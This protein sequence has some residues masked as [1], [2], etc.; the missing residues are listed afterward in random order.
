[1]KKHSVCA[2]GTVGNV[3][4]LANGMWQQCPYWCCCCR[5]PV[6]DSVK[7][8]HLSS[9][10]TTLTGQIITCILHI[11]R[12]SMSLPLLLNNKLPSKPHLP[13]VQVHKAQTIPFTAV[14]DCIADC[15]T[16]TSF[17][18]LQSLL[19]VEKFRLV[20]LGSEIYAIVFTVLRWYAD[21][22]LLLHLL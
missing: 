15:C 22:F 9:K 21:D 12:L 17:V 19:A 20:L 4:L 5:A 2:I 16:S 8:W 13:Y 11:L 6:V 18:R 10:H 7:P 3:S 14:P 1:M